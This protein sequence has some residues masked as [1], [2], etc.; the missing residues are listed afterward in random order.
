MAH[1]E[2][3]C[4]LKN[5][6]PYTLKEGEKAPQ[7]EIRANEKK[8]ILIECEH[9]SVQKLKANISRHKKACKRT[10]DNVGRGNW[11]ANSG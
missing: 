7:C 1:Y 10:K 11:T 3:S 5:E 8:G 9:F 6:R 4:A 2:K